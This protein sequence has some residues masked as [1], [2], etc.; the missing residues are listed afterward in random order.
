MKPK[1]R[2]IDQQIVE[3]DELA[4]FVRPRRLS[5]RAA[6]PKYPDRPGV[7]VL[8]NARG[9]I[10]YVGQSK[11]LC[12]RVSH[13]TALQRDTSNKEGLSHIKAALVRKHQSRLGAVFV[14]FLITKTEDEA[15][16]L[17]KRILGT[18]RA[19]WTVQ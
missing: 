2:P 19:E 4:A 15:R 17:E 3:L 6:L 16:E 11:Q 9:K 14:D 10:L 8:S 5:G 12:R 13:L 18:I 1:S 7:Y